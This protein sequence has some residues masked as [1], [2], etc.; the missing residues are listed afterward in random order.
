LRTPALQNHKLIP[1]FV[2]EEIVE[3]NVFHFN[4]FIIVTESHERMSLINVCYLF[5]IRLTLTES[6][7]DAEI[8]SKR[9]GGFVHR[10]DECF[11]FQFISNLFSES[12]TDAEIRTKRNGG[13]VHRRDERGHQQTQS[14]PRAGASAAGEEHGLQNQV[15]QTQQKVRNKITKF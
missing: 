7:T 14:Q 4:L 13:F 3:M 6:Q 9:N 5:V 12:K 10:R 8:R 15:Q 11:L 2:L 1:K